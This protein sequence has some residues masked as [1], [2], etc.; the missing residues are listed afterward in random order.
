[1]VSLGLANTRMKDFYD[2]LNLSRKFPFESEMLA[3]AI[4]NTFARRGT[5]LPFGRPLAFTAELFEDANKKRQWA[6]FCNRNRNYV[7]EVT[8][9]EV[10][11]EIDKFL[12]PVIEGLKNK[13]I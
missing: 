1:M 3:K 13:R 9:E 8:L 5:P 10:C 6:A 12:M 4:G 7:P 2:V 11:K